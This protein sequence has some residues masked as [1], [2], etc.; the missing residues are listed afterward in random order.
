MSNIENTSGYNVDDNESQNVPEQELYTLPFSILTAEAHNILYQWLEKQSTDHFERDRFSINKI[1]KKYYGCIVFWFSIKSHVALADSLMEPGKKH[2]IVIIPGNH[3]VPNEVLNLSQHYDFMKLTEI[4]PAGLSHDEFTPIVVN[5]DEVRDKAFEKLKKQQPSF[6]NED[7]SLKDGIELNMSFPAALPFWE[8]TYHQ[9]SGR[10][11]K[12][13]IE[14]QTGEIDGDKYTSAKNNVMHTLPVQPKYLIIFGITITMALMLFI[15]SLMVPHKPPKPKPAKPISTTQNDPKPKPTAQQTKPSN[16]NTSV[17]QTPQVTQEENSEAA[18]KKLMEDN[19]SYINDKKYQELYELR[20]TAIRANNSPLTY[21]E[22]YTNNI[23]IRIEKLEIEQIEND[24]AQV[25]VDY[26][27][28]DRHS[29]ENRNTIGAMR[30][31][32]SKEDGK[33]VISDSE[34][35]K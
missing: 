20:S 13:F 25:V 21:E 17:K 30:F 2:E 6:F 31:Y 12:F 18:V 35:L 27:S 14:A 28:T 22:R 26:A 33:W 24:T 3:T 32:L 29:G 5:E 1:Y 9:R 15:L 11:H 8:G 4:N 16:Q 10:D 19:F 7:D 23:G 34:Q